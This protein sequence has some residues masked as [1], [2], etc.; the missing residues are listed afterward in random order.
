MTRTKRDHAIR[1][2]KC[3]TLQRVR[4]RNVR[5]LVVIICFLVSSARQV[6]THGAESR[7]PMRDAQEFS[8]T[9]FFTKGE[10]AAVTGAFSSSQRALPGSKEDE[11]LRSW[12]RALGGSERLRRIENIYVR[13]RVETGGLSGLFEEWRVAK[14]QHKQNIELGEAYKQ[15]TVFNGHI[16]WIVDQNGSVQ[17]LTGADLESEVT[18]AYL[19]SYSYLFPG[20]MQGRVEQ[21]GE[22]ETKHAHVLNILPQGGRPVTFYLDKATSLPLRLERREAERIRTTYFSDWRD[23]D[24]L[25]MPYQLRQTV[26]EGTHNLVLTIQEVRLNVPLSPG[27]FEK[28]LASSTDLHFLL[29]RAALG[30]PFELGGSNHIFIQARVNGS[31]PSWFILDTGAAAS[32]IDVRLA[33]RLGLRVQGKLEGRRSGDRSIDVGLVKNVVFGFP[34]VEVANQSTGTIQLQSSDALLGR[35][36]NGLLGYDFFSRFVIEIDYTATKINLYDPRTYQYRGKGESIPITVEGNLPYIRAKITL[37]ARDPAQGKFLIDT[38]TSYFL[39]L[40]RSFIERNKLLEPIH[41]A[42]PPSSSATSQDE[43]VVIVD[44]NRLQLGR[45]VIKS[46]V[47]RL[48]KTTRGV[49]AN[50]DQDGIVGAEL[51]RRFKVIFD[52]SRN[53]MI[54]EPNANFDKPIETDMSG[55]DIIAEGPGFN[56]FTVR[57]VVPKSPAAEAGLLEGDVITAIDGRPATDFTLDRLSILFK[58][59]GASYRLTIKRESHLVEVTLKL[60]RAF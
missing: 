42:I 14:G 8:D 9:V 6:Y 46:P 7:S 24:G 28:P 10:A 5:H 20:R 3:S 33:E 44:G 13:G 41:H 53:R 55:A 1:D 54:L 22:D 12:E 49:E 43:Q 52:Y 40:N 60:K 58:R 27:E 19:A 25:K 48:S 38:G 39:E 56:I 30:I 29:G 18:S 23:V 31:E 36:I 35:S 21:L 37:T 59:A 17:E 57:G 45:F 47:V 51:L 26:G 11:V 32:I 50:P 2:A 15:L 16:G 4:R 34:G